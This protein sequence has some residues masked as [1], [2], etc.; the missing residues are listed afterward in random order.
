MAYYGNE[1][2]DVLLGYASFTSDW[3][4][5]L[6]YVNTDPFTE[7]E[8]SEVERIPLPLMEMSASTASTTT[9]S[10]AEEFLMGPL[11]AC[12][13]GGWFLANGET[14][15]EVM[16]VSTFDTPVVISQGN[17]AKFPVSSVNIS[18]SNS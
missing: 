16:W 9:Y 13:V 8:A 5:G 7:L 17:Y 14:E 2:F 10:N 4:F 15:T 6:Y 11:D 3:H 12:T 1:L 18:I